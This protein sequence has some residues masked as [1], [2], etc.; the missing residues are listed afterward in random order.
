[1]V[2]FGSFFLYNIAGSIAIGLC[3]AVV[4]TIK[5]KTPVAHIARTGLFA[6]VVLIGIGLVAFNV[7]SLVQ[8]VAGGLH[9]WDWLLAAFFAGAVWQTL[10]WVIAVVALF[11]TVL[12][13]YQSTTEA[14]RDY[15]R[16]VAKARMSL[17]RLDAALR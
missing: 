10:R 6:T 8:V 14:E 3:K 13:Y 17:A 15:D 7:T 12:R 11:A 5:G 9:G 16:T 4:G 1:M 2:T